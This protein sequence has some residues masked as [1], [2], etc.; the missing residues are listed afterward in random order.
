MTPNEPH[1]IPPAAGDTEEIPIVGPADD[2]EPPRGIPAF[3]RRP[4]HGHA[5]KWVRG[6][7]VFMVVAF[8]TLLGTA[9]WLHPYDEDGQP[10]TMA[11]HTQLGLPPCN[12][13]LLTGKPCPSCGMTTSFSLLMHGDLINSAKANW[14]GMLLAMY[15]AALIPW[16][17]ISAYR[18]RLMYVRSGERMM[19]ISVVVIMVLMLGRWGVVLLR[20]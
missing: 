8:S 9:A 10:R 6:V 19:T 20:P 2:L 18:G 17:A 15:W 7:L 4:R 11:T 1:D 12:M 16:A 3:A 5:A 14:V 13:V